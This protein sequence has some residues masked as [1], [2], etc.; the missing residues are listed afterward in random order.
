MSGCIC[1][2]NWQAI[3]STYEGLIGRDWKKDG[4]TF[5]FFGLV[6]SNDDY[7][8]GMW[9]YLNH[10]LVLLSCV[11]SIEGH[12]YELEGDYEIS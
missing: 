8:Y 2:G 4:H 12:G 11:G 9:D 7:Y 6:H 5:N 10:R 3:V 1:N